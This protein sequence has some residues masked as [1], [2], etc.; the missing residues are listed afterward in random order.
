M[1]NAF[2]LAVDRLV[3]IKVT[4]YAHSIIDTAWTQ[5]Q[6]K[7]VTPRG[8]YLTANACQ[9][10]DLFFA[11]RGGGGGTFG[12]LMEATVRALP[13]ISFPTCVVQSHKSL[14]K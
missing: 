6:V 5:L 11:V 9:N 12:V 8:D 10:E 4:Y 2:G 13:Q 14:D 3:G 1:S 7:V